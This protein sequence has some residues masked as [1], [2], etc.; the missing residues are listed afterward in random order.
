MPE[1][2]RLPRELLE[3]LSGK[4]FR[5]RK[6]L[7]LPLLTIDPEGYPRAAL[8]TLSEVRATSATDLCVA[9]QSKSLTAANLIRRQRAALYY[10]APE[11]GGLDPGVGGTRPGLRLGPRPSDLSARRLPGQSGSREPSGRSRGTSCRPD[12]F[13]R[14]R[15]GTLLRGALRR[16][17]KDG[18][19]KFKDR[20]VIV[21]GA[22]RGIGR[23]AAARFA[24]A[25]RAGRARRP[26]RKGARARPP[27][28]CTGTAPAASPCR[29]TS[30]SAARRKSVSRARRRSSVRPI[31]SSTT[32]ASSSG[33]RFSRPGPRN[34]I[35]SSR[36]I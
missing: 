35:S 11:A 36:P 25:G 9:V 15:R 4:G 10:L 21:T 5:A 26:H 18:R 14:G 29:P 34:G 28:S 30:R 16:A 8:L 12:F 1:F 19:M 6:H 27:R 3:I 13:R 23:S 22:G 31:F 32:P 24:E 7:A 33:G 17:G 2:D 20:V